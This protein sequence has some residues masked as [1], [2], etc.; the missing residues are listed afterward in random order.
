MALNA[1]ARVSVL[2]PVLRTRACVLAA[3]QIRDLI[4]EGAWRPGDRVPP[5][6]DLADQLGI[7]RGSVREAL[8]L[9]EALGWLEIRPGEGTVVR[10]RITAQSAGPLSDAF[11]PRTVNLGDVW[12]ARKVIEPRAA[13]L[14]AERCDKP[15]LR[16]LRAN[17]KSM[18]ARI[19]QCEWVRAIDL[20]PQFHLL[21]TRASGNGVLAD[22]QERLANF[23]QVAVNAEGNPDF[24]PERVRK[25]FEEHAAIVDAIQAGNPA[26]AERAAFRHLLDSWMAKWR[27]DGGGEGGC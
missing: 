19:R 1:S 21:V 3:E 27:R 14:A 2:R 10:A 13:Y 23:E 25:V 4:V 5:E 24:S 22:V 15:A 18:E 9:L 26:E 8:R 7:S 11:S 20:N 17:L 6:R 12:E 16:A